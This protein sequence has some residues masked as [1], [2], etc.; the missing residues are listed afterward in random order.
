MSKPITLPAANTSPPAMRV[1]L[2]AAPEVT[3][4][5]FELASL[6]DGRDFDPDLFSREIHAYASAEIDLWWQIGRRLLAA[7]A[8]LDGGSFEAWVRDH[9]PFSDRMARVYM[10]LAVMIG[11]H[12]AIQKPLAGTSLR[13]ARLLTTLADDQITQILETGTIEGVRLEQL[14]QVPYVEL[15]KKVK[16]LTRQLESVEAEKKEVE[17]T[18]VRQGDRIAELAGKT[19]I[20]R[21]TFAVDLAKVRKTIETGRTEAAI[22]LRR[23]TAE[24]A[25]GRLSP[26][27]QAELAGLAEWGRVMG[28]LDAV[29]VRQALGED[30]P[31]YAIQE[32]L[33]QPRPAAGQF[34]LP[35]LVQPGTLDDVVTSGD[36]GP[37]YVGETRI[38]TG[39][40]VECLFPSAKVY[41]AMIAAAVAAGWDEQAAESY[42]KFAAVRK[43]EVEQLLAQLDAANGAPVGG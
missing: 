31:A 9:L 19:T 22:I 40:P 18:V 37:I 11:R 26:E 24:Q 33:E 6:T 17:A 27:Q 34:P 43:T 41:Q 3:A 30:V 5:G 13:R 2:D 16:H 29:A 38:R 20:N 25:A 1:A 28:E 21:E 36:D 42:L 15:E 4:E 14:D 35:M 23:L 8:C 10:Q 12:P 32:I 39:A 7:K